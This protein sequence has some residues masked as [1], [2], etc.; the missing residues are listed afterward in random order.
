MSEWVVEFLPPP[1]QN[2][3]PLLFLLPMKLLCLEITLSRT[4]LVFWGEQSGKGKVYDLLL[5]VHA[6]L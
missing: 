5:T 2:M 6:T 1:F 4:K 3:S